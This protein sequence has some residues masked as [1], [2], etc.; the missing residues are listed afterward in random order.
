MR[1]I[2]LSRTQK[3]LIAEALREYCF[4]AGKLGNY[5][6][7]A[8]ILYRMGLPQHAA[9][10]EDRRDTLAKLRPTDFRKMMQERTR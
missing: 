6:R 1:M 5:R 7:A 10:L 8:S 4:A 3:V 2:K 9:F